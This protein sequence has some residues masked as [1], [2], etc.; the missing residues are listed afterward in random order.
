MGG[1]PPPA[2]GGIGCPDSGSPRREGAGCPGSPNG[3]VWASCLALVGWTSL[4][5]GSRVP[6]VWKRWAK[7]SRHPGWLVGSC[8]QQQ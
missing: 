6:M 5:Q 7:A 1:M 4:R 2:W 8:W 3:P